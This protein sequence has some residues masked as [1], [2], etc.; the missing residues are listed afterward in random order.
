MSPLHLAAALLMVTGASRCARAR[1]G[2][3]GKPL[4]TPGRRMSPLH[5]AAA[6]L[7]V[8]IWGFNFVVIR[9]GL[10]SVSPYT[11]NLLRFILASFPA[12]LFVRPPRAPWR[13]DRGLRPVCFRDAVQPALR[14]HG[15]GH[16][17][18]TR[19][20]RHP[21]AGVLHDRP[22]DTGDAR[23]CTARRSSSGRPWSPAR[24]SCWSP[25]ICRR[26]R[27]SA[28]LVR[29]GAASWATANVI[30]KRI[31]G[32][33]T[34]GRR[35]L[36]QRGRR[37]RDA[38]GRAGGRWPGLRLVAPSPAWTRRVAR[39]GLPGLADHAAGVRHLG[40][41]AAPASGGAGRAVHA[42]R[43]DRRHDLRGAAARRTG[44]VVEAG[45]RRTGTRRP[46]AQRGSRRGKSELH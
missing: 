31:P 25:C 36:G 22:G 16:A 7:M 46:G 17:D 10:N 33:P 24:A 12:L 23:A 30:V 45:R 19:I 5:L 1:W 18:R 4:P 20:A 11:L 44:H 29:D 40:L 39:R 27:G 43:A 21:G 14:R 37:G 6:L 42:A 38:A 13:I 8:T 9:W 35:G 26:P 15:G 34:A 41:A 32:D 28:W 2:V 3:C